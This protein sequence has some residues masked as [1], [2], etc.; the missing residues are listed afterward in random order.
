MSLPETLAVAYAL[1][2][3]LVVAFQLALAAGAPW[4]SYAMG[5]AFPGRMPPSLRVAAVIQGI[6]LGAL[7]IVVLADAGLLDVPILEGWP[8]LI[9][10]P[11]AVAG[12]AVLLNGSTRS[13][14]ERRIWLPVAVVLL[15]CSLAVALA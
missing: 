4:G 13:R 14:G 10:V 1:V 8:W 3:A 12:V 9:W 11:V 5:G 6:F 15:L 2:T 7:A